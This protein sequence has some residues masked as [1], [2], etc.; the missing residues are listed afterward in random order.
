MGRRRKP[1][2]GARPLDGWV[3]VDK[4]LGLTSAQVVS[5]LRHSLKP[6]RIGHAGTLDPLASGVLPVALGEA[7]KTV[8]YAMDGAKTYLFTLQFGQSR[9]TDDAEGEITG[10]SPRRPETEALRAILPRFTGHLRQRP[11]AFSA[12][13]L[14]GRRAYDLARAGL[15][16]EMAERDIE[17]KSLDLV[18]RPGPDTADFTVTCGKG[19]YIRALARD[20][21]EAVGTLGHVVALR[22]TRVGPF[23]E[24]QAIALD[25]L[26]A[27]GHSAPAFEYL[28]P[29]ETA[30][31][32]IPA[33]ALTG[34]QAD[35]LRQGRAVA[36]P[37]TGATR[38]REGGADKAAAISD[39]TVVCA[40]E[41]S[42]LVALARFGAGVLHPVRVLNL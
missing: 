2:E 11:P 16:P 5:R 18:A 22:R 20:L 23:V 31:D 33:L 13:K 32:D 4:P 37:G 3:V 35:L 27:L 39:G 25:K 26:I 36:V 10:E 1:P 30:L 38:P 6:L 15:A 29:I 7:T 24:N 41:G 12:I 9:A 21:A 42:R 19:T 34:E 8:A 17:I 28:L 40:M 14:A